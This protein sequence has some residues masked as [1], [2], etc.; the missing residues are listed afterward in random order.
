MQAE[1]NLMF[2][3]DLAHSKYGMLQC[4]EEFIELLRAKSLIRIEGRFTVTLGNN[5]DRVQF[6]SDSTTYK[7][8]RVNLPTTMLLANPTGLIL[9]GTTDY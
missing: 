1:T 8:V 6:A 7:I 3:P 9:K 4:T 5:D 2:G